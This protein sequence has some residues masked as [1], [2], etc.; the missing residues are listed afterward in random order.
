MAPRLAV[1]AV[2]AALACATTT[3][4]AGAGATV[5]T[6][7]LG[8]NVGYLTDSQYYAAAFRRIGEDGL[9]HTRFMGPFTHAPGQ[10]SERGVAWTAGLLRNVTA[11]VGPGASVTLSLSDYPYDVQQDLLSDPSKY[12]SDW[13]GKPATAVLQDTLRYTNRAPPSRGAWRNG[14]L[15]TYLDTLRTLRRELDAGGTPVD[16]EIGNE[17][18][19]LLYFWGNA[20]DFLPIADGALASLGPVPALGPA[21]RPPRVACCAFATELGGQGLRPGQDGGFYEFAQAV[22]QRHRA[23]A[24][25]KFPT[26]LS[27]H[28]Y[29]QSQNDANAARST[30]ANATAFYG[31]AALNQSVI[32]EW[33]LSTY[34]SGLQAA[35]INGPELVLELVRLLGFAAAVGVAQVD[36]HCLMDDPHKGGHDCYFDRFGQPRASYHHYALVARV[37]RGGYLCSGGGAALTNVTGARSGLTILAAAGDADGR[38]ARAGTAY[39]PPGHGVVA[40]SAAVA[41][42]PDPDARGRSLLRLGVGAWI[43]TQAEGTAAFI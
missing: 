10:A 43:V 32:S 19:A 4:R 26:A 34:N 8:F 21:P 31:P 23:M 22:T 25:G 2:L 1:P 3:S 27:W 36:A 35:R 33:G 15:A 20:D 38:G 24:G 30:Y 17:V 13:V 28:F 29:R 16:Y 14:T 18:N 41:A 42:V 9:R 39:L 11:A 7:R 6:L 40:S 37:I 12:L 5:H